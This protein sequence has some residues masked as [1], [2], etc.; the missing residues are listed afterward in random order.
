MLCARSGA[1]AAETAAA[2]PGE[3]AR[4]ELRMKV[5]AA[6]AILDTWQGHPQE[7]NE[8]KL[9]IVYWTPADREP[10]PE[11]RERLSKILEDIRAFYAREMERVGFGPRTIQLD[12]AAD[13]L[14]RIHLVRGLKPY[15]D[16]D[17]RS[18]SEIRGESTPTLLK[19]GINAAQETI[20]IF[21]NMSQWDAEKR[22]ITQ[23]S[24][25]YAGGTLRSGTAWQV[26]SPILRLESLTEKADHVQDGQYG[27]ISLGKYNSIFIGGIAHE[28]GHALT[29]PHCRARE[30]ERIAFGTSLM[31]SGNLT[32][33]TDRRGEGSGSFLTLSEALRLAG[34]PIFS[35]SNK[36]MEL[37]PSV[38]P[39]EIQISRKDKG[40]VFSGRVQ[41][42]P[43]VYGIIGYMDP[44]GGSD[45]DATTA[46]AV[47]DAEGRFTLDCQALKAGKPGELRVVYLQANGVPSGALS[48]T[49]YRYPY[50]VDA[51]GAV[52]ITTA[53]SKLI[54]APLIAAVYARDMA[55]A[56]KLAGDAAVANDPK[57]KRIAQRLMGTLETPKRS[58]P[59]DVPVETASAAL[60]D[61]AAQR[62]TTGYGPSRR[63]LLPENR[64]LLMAG[65]EVYIHGFYAHAEATQEWQLDDRW[66]TISGHIGLADG[67][68]GSVQGRIEGDGKVLWESKAIKDGPAVPFQVNVEGVKILTLKTTDAGD[69]KRG[70]WALWLEP[71][72]TR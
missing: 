55:L 47:P 27:R 56:Q 6:R 33:G 72:L 59:A 31:G 60:S 28:V 42:D 16:Y 43:P 34:H 40:F 3:A 65:G 24:P 71:T 15:K 38:V 63:D 25:Y 53:R 54:L 61:L 41:A 58:S 21:C 45:Y 66:K 57:L 22:V 64:G 19:A 36:G 69:G 26:D 1:A 5:P 62:E 51:S 39:S 50:V 35:G 49:P 48:S 9:H 20:V 29:L 32:Y 46:T 13:G 23:N 68:D 7:R 30:D 11:Y 70:D 37:P 12:H 2:D 44:A 4:A 18:G 67:S 52:D 10:A 17:G 14:V 8:R